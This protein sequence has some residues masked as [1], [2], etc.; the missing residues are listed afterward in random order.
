MRATA[1]AL[2]LI[3]GLVAPA[4]AQQAPAQQAPGPT[5]PE[6]FAPEIAAFAAADRAHAPTPCG[7]LFVGS[8][9][10]RFWKT[11]EADMAPVPAINRGFG[12]STIAD[13]DY[14]FDQVVTPYR[15]RAIVFYA[16]ENDINAGEAPSI[17]TGN[18]A[19]FM[20]LKTKAF[21]A[22]TPVY[23]ISLKPS[24]LRWLQRDRQAQVNAQVQA[25]AAQRR[26]L[27]YI[28]VAPAM[29]VNGEP[30]DIYVADGLHMTP[31]GYKLW[32]EVIRPVV[33]AEAK[34]PTECKAS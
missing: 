16:G 19:R 1:L 10:I 27:H 24:K 12:G 13:V 23:F 7:F 9:S 2:A 29:L 6:R 22:A 18:F 3:A 4:L 25:L 11:L 28:D 21:G 17:V 31:E 32:T 15:P 14:Y 26:D 34:R 8:S 33:H 20:E 30:K 5:G